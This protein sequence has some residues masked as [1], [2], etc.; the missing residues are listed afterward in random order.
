MNYLLVGLIQAML[1]SAEVKGISTTHLNA[2]EHE[3]LPIEVQRVVEESENHLVVV[4]Q[5]LRLKPHITVALCDA[6]YSLEY[7][8]YVYI[9]TP[10]GKIAI[11]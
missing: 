2:D 4:D 8:E 6:G 10:K 1:Q 11:G 3:L 7:N 5:G 9:C